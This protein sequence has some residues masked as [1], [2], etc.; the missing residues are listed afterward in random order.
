MRK[1]LIIGSAL[2]AALLLGSGAFAG[3]DT[4][5]V[6]ARTKLDVESAFVQTASTWDVPYL[7]PKIKPA[8]GP[9]MAS[10]RDGYDALTHERLCSQD[11]TETAIAVPRIVTLLT[12]RGTLA[13]IDPLIDPGIWATPQEKMSSDLRL[14]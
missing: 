3:S 5:I 8:D 10:L 11:R 9:L 1:I 2:A 6:D 14:G 12:N 7:L 4:R 13:Y